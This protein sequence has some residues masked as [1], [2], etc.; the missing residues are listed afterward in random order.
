MARI[1]I[2]SDDRQSA[3][4]WQSL[5]STEHD[6]WLKEVP[7]ADTIR[8]FQP[9]DGMAIV[10]TGVIAAD[11]GNLAPLARLGLKLLIVG[12]DWTEDK[13]IYALVVGCYG[14]CEAGAANEFLAK[15]VRSVLQGYLWIPRHLAPRIIGMLARL[16]PAVNET[17]KVRADLR[18]NIELLTQ[19][20]RDV[21]NM[22]GEGL[23]NKLIASMLNISE[24]TVKA[25]LTSIFHKLD[26]Q[27]RLQLALLIKDKVY[28]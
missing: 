26:V 14:Y 5:L 25:H 21:A 10:H 23:S 1:L 24:R 9:T 11:L 8:D 6:V 2:F 3:N 12:A 15:A 16:H 7:R 4:Q 19:R 20:E 13:Q 27:D 18:Q 22:L 17:E 28:I